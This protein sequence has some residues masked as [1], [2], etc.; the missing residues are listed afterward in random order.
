MRA[1]HPKL[2]WS[3]LFTIICPPVVVACTVITVLLVIVAVL[4]MSY[5][6]NP[7]T[8]RIDRDITIYVE[9]FFLAVAFL[10]TLICLLAVLLPRHTYLDK[11]GAGRFRTK[12]LILT[13][14][15]CILTLGAGWRCAIAWMEEVPITAAVPWYLSKAVFY[16]MNFGI[17]ITVLV[18]YLIT[19]VDRR[20]YVP[21]GASGPFSYSGDVVADDNVRA[22]KEAAARGTPWGNSF[23]LP[24]FDRTMPSQSA[25]GILADIPENGEQRNSMSTVTLNDRYGYQ[26][27]N[28]GYY[29]QHHPQSSEWTIPKGSEQREA[30]GPVP[31]SQGRRSEH[32]RDHSQDGRKMS[33]VSSAG[34]YLEVDKA[35]RWKLRDVDDERLMP[36]EHAQQQ[37]QQGPNGSQ[38]TLGGASMAR[39]FT[40]LSPLFLIGEVY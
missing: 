4:Q 13:F 3:P 14:A 27:Y 21:D 16:I 19:R 23:Y 10:P 1:R 31:P 12:V 5:V 9:T 6:T 32:S 26:G 24:T 22:E 36:G 33:G 34:S 40:R 20:F 30:Y 18:L 25:E 17:E 28:N 2:G 15:S 7:N 29:S 11:F 39:K 37:Q 38:W 35:G 8:L